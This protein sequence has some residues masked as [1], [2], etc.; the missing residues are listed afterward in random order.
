MTVAKAKA[1]NTTVMAGVF[2]MLLVYGALIF[3]ALIFYE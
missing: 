1:I 3:F 2:S